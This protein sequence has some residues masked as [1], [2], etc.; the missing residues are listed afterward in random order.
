MAKSILLGMDLLHY[1]L[2]KDALS[3]HISM[4]HLGAVV[5][6]ALTVSAA[7]IAASS[8]TDTI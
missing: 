2:V 1:P 8:H 4:R 5:V 6:L 7:F 3:G